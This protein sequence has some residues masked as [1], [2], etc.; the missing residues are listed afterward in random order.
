LKAKAQSSLAQAAGSADTWM[1]IRDMRNALAAA[2]RVIA[3][4][5][6][7]SEFIREKDALDIP[8]GIGVRSQQWLDAHP[9]NSEVSSG[10]KTP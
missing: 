10:A 9:P 3:N 2:M 8:D 1:L 7:T 6:L 5:G 4:G